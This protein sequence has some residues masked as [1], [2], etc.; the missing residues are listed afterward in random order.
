MPA[1][2]T[3]RSGRS[4]LPT[5]S[6]SMPSADPPERADELR[7]R[8]EDA[9]GERAPALIG[10]QPDQPERRQRELRHDQQRRH[11]VDAHQR[12]V[13]AV[14]VRRGA[15]GG[16]P[17][18]TR[19]GRGGLTMNT[20][21]EH[22]RHRRPA[23][24]RRA[25]AR[26]RRIRRPPARGT[27]TAAIATPSGCHICRMP[28]ANPRR[29]GGNQPITTRPLAALVE[30]AAIPVRTRKSRAGGAC[31]RARGTTVEAGARHGGTGAAAAVSSSPPASTQRSP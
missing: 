14:R 21:H 2:A 1:N 11:E 18:R 29:S 24:P 12:P 15:A 7:R 20:A 28:I 9:G 19:A 5:R 8:D 25:R 13:G 3:Q 22:R 4:R 6:L 23:R 31:P 16:R 17:P 26:Q 10:D 27:A 30:A